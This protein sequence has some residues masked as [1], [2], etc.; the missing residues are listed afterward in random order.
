[1]DRTCHA[2]GSIT[3][4][5]MAARDRGQVPEASFSTESECS[6]SSMCRTQVAAVDPVEHTVNLCDTATC[7]ACLHIHSLSCQ[8]V[9]KACTTSVAS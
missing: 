9:C 7:M 3:S 6:R 8:N 1:M 2:T 5:C 4:H